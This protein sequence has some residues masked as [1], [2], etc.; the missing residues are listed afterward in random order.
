M[1]R[2]PVLAVPW[3]LLVPM[4]LL[5]NDAPPPYYLNAGL[6]TGSR[7][8]RHD[9][10]DADRPAEIARLKKLAAAS[11]GSEPKERQRQEGG[12]PGFTSRYRPSVR[13]NATC[14]R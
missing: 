3:C 14:W 13:W 8:Q 2:I 7:D 4:A 9:I 6:Q 11:C 12:L 10:E 1:K 5:C